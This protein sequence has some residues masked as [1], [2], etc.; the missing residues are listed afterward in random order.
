MKSAP[1][2]ALR[3]A[4]TEL[5]QAG[6]GL[7]RRLLPVVIAIA[8]LVY[9]VHGIDLDKLQ[10][11]LRRAPLGTLLFVSAGMT[12]LNCAADTFAM[13]HVFRGF[14]LRLRFFDLYTIRAATYTLAVINYHAGQLGIIGFLHR[15]SRVP[16]PLASAYILFI[17]G[18]WVALLMIFATFGALVGG[19]KGQALLPVL[20]LFALGLFVYAALLRWPPRFLRSPPP[21][22]RGPSAGA[23]AR[24][25]QRAW[26]LVGTLWQPL[27]EAGLSGHLRALLVRLPHLGVLL[28]WHFIALRCFRVEVPFHLAMLYL[29]VVFAVTALPISVQ[30]LGTAQV[31]ARYYFSDFAAQSGAGGGDEAVLAYSLSMTAISTASNLLMGLLFLRRGT[32]LGLTA[33]ATTADLT[34]APSAGSLPAAAASPSAADQG[35]GSRAEKRAGEQPRGFAAPKEPSSEED[36]SAVR[37]VIYTNSEDRLI[38]H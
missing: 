4:G 8:A 32:R 5:R 15:A 7:P 3:R 23:L 11:V 21:A 2:S 30:G 33:A 37:S 35:A 6:S 28:I 14:G 17:V 25:W 31:V 20:G 12:L 36:A 13:Y 16:L 24:L 27:S 18:V 19:P 10:L 38:L 26:R 29:P 9:A 1:I 22:E 34:A